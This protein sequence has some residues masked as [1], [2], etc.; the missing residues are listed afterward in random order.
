MHASG[1]VC[2]KSTDS[3]IRA[4][5]LNG[6]AIRAAQSLGLHLRD[7][8]SSISPTERMM[9]ARIWYSIKS[10]E[11]MLTVI[12]GRPSMINDEDCTVPIVHALS[13][14]PAPSVRDTS[15]SEVSTAMDFSTQRSSSSMSE[16]SQ[17][18]LKMKVLEQCKTPVAST[19]FLHYTELCAL[20]K[21]VVGDLYH[22]KIRQCK[23]F[24]V[25]TK[26]D[27]FNKRLHQ[28]QDSLSPMFKVIA[29]S[30]D[31]EIESCRIA[32]LILFHSTSTII[33]RPCLCRI[34]ERMGVQSS[35]SKNR[36][37]GF[38]NT[39]VESA[40]HILDLILNEPESTILHQ[41]VTWW[42]L[43]HHLKRA[44]T[45]ILLELAFRA[46]HMPAE[47]AAI[48]GQA[49]KAV[50][51]LR[52]LGSSSPMARCTWISMSKL[53]YPAALKVGG[54]T[55]DIAILPESLQYEMQRFGRA[56]Q[57]Q[58]LRPYD[59][60]GYPNLFQPLGMYGTAEGQYF[61]DLAA[62]S[63]LDQFGFDS[64]QGHDE[65]M[66]F[67]GGE[68]YYDSGMLGGAGGPGGR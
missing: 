28:W 41:G 31:S 32:L 53:L 8:T 66:N 45:V 62:R 4:W 52:W 23:W 43:L 59:A 13:E 34:D 7:T 20:A 67:D 6:L 30:A 22:P 29:K 65:Q 17:S 42:M 25:Q 37:H 50:A 11:S 16:P 2:M 19:Y 48:L 15:P 64:W 38:A 61:G 58:Q 9:R 18:A 44:L 5:N 47:A 51:W 46:E 57:L 21:E 1:L 39:C 24:E 49:K 68:L 56:T 12:T 10:L 3:V 40:R 14:E 63:E 35:A 55:S 54:D 27:R 60:A 36:N 33:N 26:M